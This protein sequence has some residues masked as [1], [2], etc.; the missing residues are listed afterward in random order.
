MNG[1]MLIKYRTQ[2]S[3]LVLIKESIN[4]VLNCLGFASKEAKEHCES[5]ATETSHSESEERQHFAHFPKIFSACS[6]KQSKHDCLSQALMSPFC[7]SLKSHNKHCLGFEA[8]PLFH[9]LR[10]RKISEAL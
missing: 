5:V 8:V 10:L 7:F 9:A 4:S 6:Q 1:F 2:L 3:S